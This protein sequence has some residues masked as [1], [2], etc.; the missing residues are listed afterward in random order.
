MPG[1]NGRDNL[2]QG[3]VECYHCGRR[4][5][6]AKDPQSPAREKTCSKCSQ[7]GQFANLSKTKFIKLSSRSRVRY[8]QAQD[9]QEEE[10]KYVFVVI[11]GKITLYIEGIPLKMIIDSGAGANVISAALWELLKKQNI[12]CHERMQRSCMLMVQLHLLKS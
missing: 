2:P 4:G 9:C 11:G 7:P 10:D 8:M 6:F 3:G 12:A 1:R 5:H